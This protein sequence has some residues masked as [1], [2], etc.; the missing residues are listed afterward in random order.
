MSLK[1]VA[2]EWLFHLNQ[3]YCDHNITTKEQLSQT[4]LIVSFPY[5]IWNVFYRSSLVILARSHTLDPIMSLKY[6]AFEWLFHL[7]QGYCD[8]N[9]TNN[10]Q[11]SQTRLIVSFP[12]IIRNVFH[13][14][15]L[16][17][18]YLS[19]TLDHIMSLK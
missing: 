6:V 4:S 5:I 15:S 13:R 3:G 9:I 12:Y 10:D 7:R 17:I 1:K 8:Y 19:H 14:S 2:F 18:V 11:L 16:V